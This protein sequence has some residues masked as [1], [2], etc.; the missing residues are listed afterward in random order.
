MKCSPLLVIVCASLAFAGCKPKPKE[1][2]P[3]QRKEAATLVGEAQFALTLRDNARAEPL[4]EKAA[5][6]CPDRGDYWLGLGVTRKKLGNPSGA[7]AA[8]ENARDA[9]HEAYALQPRNIDALMQEIHVLALLGKADEARKILAKARKKDP[10][11]SQLKSIEED[12]VIDDLL[13]DPGFK[14]VA[15]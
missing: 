7:K 3:L 8:Y 13:A 4:L 2:S 12:K 10:T 9:F 5:K 15:L 14:E 11:N 1:I 6:L